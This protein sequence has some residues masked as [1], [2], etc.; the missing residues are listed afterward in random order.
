[1]ELLLTTKLIMEQRTNEVTP[2]MVAV[3]FVTQVITLVS[4]LGIPVDKQEFVCQG[5]MD[6]PNAVRCYEQ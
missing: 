2:Y 6:N 5:I 3:V 1:M 4:V